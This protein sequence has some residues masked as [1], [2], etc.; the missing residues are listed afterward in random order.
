MNPLFLAQTLVSKTIN[1]PSTI[2]TLRYASGIV[3]SWGYDSGYGF[4]LIEGDDTSKVH[5]RYGKRVDVY[6]H[7]KNIIMPGYKY[8]TPGC[9]VT[10]DLELTDKGP[11]A[12][13][14]MGPGVPVEKNTMDLSK[15]LEA[16]KLWIDP[17]S[18]INELCRK[19]KKSRN[20]YYSSKETLPKL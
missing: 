19:V 20:A 5:L 13:N 15:S 11:K 6:V 8:L 2:T 4:I 1:N 16:S 12:I 9:R 17:P 14:V 18:N 10:F 7:Y 3:K